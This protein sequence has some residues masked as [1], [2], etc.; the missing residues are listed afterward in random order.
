MTVKKCD[1]CGKIYEKGFMLA[2]SLE[3]CEVNKGIAEL[4]PEY[5]H[6]KDLCETCARRLMMFLGSQK[7][8]KE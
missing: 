5:A 8:T 7:E 2:Y 1:K 3:E 6:R 4:K